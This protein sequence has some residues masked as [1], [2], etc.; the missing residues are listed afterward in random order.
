MRSRPPQPRLTRCGASGA[1]WR[2]HAQA[3]QC[4][5][6]YGVFLHVRAF[7]GFE[8]FGDFVEARRGHDCAEGVES[9]LS[10]SDMLVAIHSG[11]AGDFGIVEVKGGEMF[12]ADDAV[13]LAEY[14]FGGWRRGKVV[15]CGE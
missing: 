7:W 5:E 9:D 1:E 13:E 11:A 14:R 8:D 3:E 6:I 4:G 12:T 15:A 10:L 2:W